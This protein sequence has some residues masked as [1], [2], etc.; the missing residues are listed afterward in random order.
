MICLFVSVCLVTKKQGFCY[1]TVM[2]CKE[3]GKRAYEVGAC[4][5]VRERVCVWDTK[6]QDCV[7]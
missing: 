4:M 7:K 1:D 3:R 6:K 2:R 5:C